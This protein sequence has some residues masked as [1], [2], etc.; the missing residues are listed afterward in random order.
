[1]NTGIISLPTPVLHVN[2]QWRA[3]V[4][5]DATRNQQGA[6]D[7]GNGFRLVNA[8][9]NVWQVEKTA[10][11]IF[12]VRFGFEMGSPVCLCGSVRPS[13]SNVGVAYLR[14]TDTGRRD[15]R[16]VSTMEQSFAGGAWA[17]LNSDDTFFG[18]WGMV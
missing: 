4:H 18:F 16:I 8:A 10:D 14:A 2:S 6:V 12:T 7:A 17:T 5:F 9:Y 1:M 11:G 13:A 15:E 3:W